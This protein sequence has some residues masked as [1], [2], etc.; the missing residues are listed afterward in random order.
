MTSKS[1]RTVALDWHEAQLRRGCDAA[2]GW[3]APAASVSIGGLC[4][5]QCRTT[6]TEG[7]EPYGSGKGGQSLSSC[8]VHGWRCPRSGQWWRLDGRRQAANGM[9]MGLRVLC[10]LTYES[11]P[12]RWHGEWLGLVCKSAALRGP[13]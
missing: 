12:G 6:V 9:G 7:T 10:A 2:G 1:L 11:T 4:R 13:P 5:V 3:G 8:V